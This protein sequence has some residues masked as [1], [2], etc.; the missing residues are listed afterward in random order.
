MLKDCVFIVSG[1]YF[2]RVYFLFFCLVGYVCDINLFQIYYLQ[3]CLIIV[4]LFFQFKF[5]II[6][7][8]FKFYIDW[9]QF[10]FEF[11]GVFNYDYDEWIRFRIVCFICYCNFL[12]IWGN[13]LD[14]DLM[15]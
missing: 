12:L 11:G 7:D 1:V 10:I 14:F 8:E 2:G 6:V 5:I 15:F 9:I 13:F 3:Y 4:V